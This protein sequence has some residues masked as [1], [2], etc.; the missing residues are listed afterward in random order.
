MSSRANK[1]KS[2]LLWAPTSRFWFALLLALVGIGQIMAN[3]SE[4]SAATLS[5]DEAA[6]DSARAYIFFMLHERQVAPETVSH[7]VDIPGF[8]RAGDPLW[9]VRFI[10][11]G[12][13]LQTLIW[14]NKE[15]GLAYFACRPGE[16]MKDACAFYARSRERDERAIDHDGRIMEPNEFAEIKVMPPGS[17]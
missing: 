4:V 17:D 12:T 16:W 10:G 13:G 1:R 15:T 3:G 2:R 8:A 5:R 6:N 7:D 14:I 9:E 11:K